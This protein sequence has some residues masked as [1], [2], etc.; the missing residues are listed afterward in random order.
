[1]KVFHIVGKKNNGKTTLVTE[2]IRE[3]CSRGLRVASVKHC[4]HAHQLDTPGKDSHQH[5]MAGADPVAI[6]TTERIAFS[7]KREPQQNPYD[8][9]RGAFSTYDLTVIEGDMDGPG[10]KV[11]VW[12]GDSPAKNPLCNERDD[13]E[14]VVTDDALETNAMIHRRS[15]IV[16]LADKLIA[17]AEEI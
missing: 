12:R 3:F 10:P 11:E 9:L 2:L 1:M 16:G 14:F 5:Q 4:G 8:V 17:L 15:D 7:Q 13:I 6:I